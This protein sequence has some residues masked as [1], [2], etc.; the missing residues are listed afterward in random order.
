M[1]D[2][3]SY[4]AAKETQACGAKE[5]RDFVKGL[6]KTQRRYKKGKKEK[7]FSLGG[8]QRGPEGPHTVMNIRMLVPSH[9]PS[10]DNILSFV[11]PNFSTFCYILPP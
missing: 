9:P 11:V 7:R 2:R 5:T 4:H 6:R 1:E 8:P 3:A 10:C